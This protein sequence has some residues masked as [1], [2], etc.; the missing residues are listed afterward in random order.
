MRKLNFLLAAAGAMMASF[1]AHAGDIYVF[2]SITA[3]EH[4]NNDSYTWNNTF[5]GVMVGQTQV[6]TVTV[7]MLSAVCSK[8]LYTMLEQPGKYTLRL[9]IDWAYTSGGTPYGQY[10]RSCTLRR[11]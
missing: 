1:G 10:T 9:D 3:I 11:V 5:S 8:H 4:E 6:V 2:T 7:P